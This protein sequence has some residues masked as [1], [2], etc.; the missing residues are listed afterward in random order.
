MMLCTP[1]VNHGCFNAQSNPFRNFCPSKPE[2]CTPHRVLA[3][4]IAR[5]YSKVVISLGRGLSGWLRHRLAKC[6]VA[7]SN[8]TGGHECS[9]N[10]RNVRIVVAST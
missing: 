10:S 6:L 4:T 5:K 1:G 8:S 2:I 9:N 3:T 7:S